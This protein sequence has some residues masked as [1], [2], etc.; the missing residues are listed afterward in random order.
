M[1]NYTNSKDSNDA[2]IEI[3]KK[4]NEE[5]KNNKRNIINESNNRD[6]IKDR[7]DRDNKK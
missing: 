3:A 7:N 4:K 1:K 6:N 2:L 5:I